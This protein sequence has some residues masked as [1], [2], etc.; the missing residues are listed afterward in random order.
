MNSRALMRGAARLFVFCGG[1]DATKADTPPWRAA[2]AKPTH[3]LGAE[4]LNL[5][6]RDARA[7]SPLAG[8]RRS[9]RV[10][11]DKRRAE[12]AKCNA[13]TEAYSKSN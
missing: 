10:K 8:H 5:L 4:A 2:T 9:S 6:K 1:A 7:R 13:D 11:G 12:I 3:S